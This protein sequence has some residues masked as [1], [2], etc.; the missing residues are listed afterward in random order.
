MWSLLLHDTGFLSLYQIR[1]SDFFESEPQANK[2]AHLHRSLSK[3]D[4]LKFLVHSVPL[5]LIIFLPCQ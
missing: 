1:G 3:L 2:Q 4:T 5:L